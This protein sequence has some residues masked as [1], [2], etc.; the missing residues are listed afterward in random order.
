MPPIKSQSWTDC[1]ACL[2][3]SRSPTFVGWSWERIR[4]YCESCGDELHRRPTTTGYS[5][6]EAERRRDCEQLGVPYTPRGESTFRES[7]GP[8]RW[9]AHSNNYGITVET[10][11]TSNRIKI[12]GVGES[13]FIQYL[14]SQGWGEEDVTTL[15]ETLGIREAKQS[16]V[17]A[18]LAKGASSEHHEKPFSPEICL[19]IEK[20]GGRIV[21][22]ED[23]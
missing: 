22:V 11:D 16:T 21:E 9:E 10:S 4:S 17:Q 7:T 1:S 18:H 23:S 2:V 19:A 5:E 6:R 3:R 20:A 15:Y 12:C 14:G 13:D 8:G